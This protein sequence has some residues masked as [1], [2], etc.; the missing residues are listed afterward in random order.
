MEY[1]IIELTTSTPVNPQPLL[2]GGKDPP[3]PVE[4]RTSIGGAVQ[5]FSALSTYLGNQQSGNFLCSVSDFHLLLFLYSS[6]VAGFD[7]KVQS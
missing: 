6:G 7:F 5:D 1:L 4:N 3:F 2:V